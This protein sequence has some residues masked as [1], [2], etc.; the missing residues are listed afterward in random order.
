[1]G[2]E[3]HQNVTAAKALSGVDEVIVDS[4]PAA[5]VSAPC[6][7]LASNSAKCKSRQQSA[8]VLRAATAQVRHLSCIRRDLH[9]ESAHRKQ[10]PRHLRSPASL[11]PRVHLPRCHPLLHL[12][13]AY[14][15]RL[16][17]LNAP[18][19]TDYDSSPKSTALTR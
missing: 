14:R 3:T 17:P 7:L 19:R 18:L 11:S 6:P 13:E 12:L 1:M 15:A 2:G 10:Q 9:R 8:P 16:S 5:F 4:S